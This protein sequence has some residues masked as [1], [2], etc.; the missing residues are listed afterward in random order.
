[1]V[2]GTLHMSR[3]IEVEGTSRIEKTI[4]NMKQQFVICDNIIT[5]TMLLNQLVLRHVTFKLCQFL[6]HF[7]NRFHCGLTCLQDKFKLIIVPFD[8]I[9]KSLNGPMQASST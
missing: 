1:V 3:S 7:F 4:V 6:L 9:L 5:I 2:I 8:P